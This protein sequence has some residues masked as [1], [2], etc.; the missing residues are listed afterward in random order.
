LIEILVVIAIVSILA[1]ILF[2]VLGR[3]RENARRSACQSNLKQLA[4]ASLQYAA[5]YDNYTLGYTAGIDRKMALYPYTK[6]GASNSDTSRNQVWTCPS[7]HNESGEASY[8][9]NTKMNRVHLAAIADPVNTVQAADAGIND[10][11][12]IVSATH[13]MAPTVAPSPAN[14]RP[15]P[16]HFDGVNV[17][18]MD[19][20]VKWRKLELPFFP[21]T[22]AQ[23][24]GNGITDPNDP[25][26]RDQ[27]WDLY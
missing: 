20:H 2:P 24:L 6:S 14:G 7:A 26:Y 25:N 22:A 8:G 10:F 27:L 4:L 19:G 13:L 5:D 3:A 15:N 17:A 12:G 16:R 1:A 11:G 18:W 9:F 21:R 23:G